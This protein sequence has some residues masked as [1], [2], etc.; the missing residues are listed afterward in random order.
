MRDGTQDCG[1]ISVDFL[2]GIA[3]FLITFTFI[4]QV[5]PVMFTPLQGEETDL[6]P[7]AYRVGVMLA[8]DPGYWSNN[9]N[10]GTDWENHPSNVKRVGLANDTYEQNKLDAPKI[11]A[12]LNMTN[13]ELRD[14]LGL[15]TSYK[16][17]NYNITLK[18]PSGQVI[19]LDNQWVQ[20][21]E[22]IPEGVKTE[23][24]TRTVSMGMA[25]PN[26]PYIATKSRK[27]PNP[28]NNWAWWPRADENGPGKTDPPLELTT[29]VYD[30][31]VYLKPTTSPN[32]K[33]Y[34]QFFITDENITENQNMINETNLSWGDPNQWAG[35][36]VVPGPEDT[37]MSNWTGW[38]Y[39]DPWYVYDFG[40]FIEQEYPEEGTPIKISIKYKACYGFVESSSFYNYTSSSSYESTT[41]IPCRLEVVVW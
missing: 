33:R 30:F 24:I 10:N 28:P 38:E 1:Q 13:D 2:T 9:T 29:P 8:E 19:K 16:T 34:F 27:L 31:V 15:N 12:M 11:N 3:I 20:M 26:I 4:L 37:N 21:G 36:P 22:P 7:V 41:L 40:D 25:E 39:N 6:H 32:T 14:K 17:Y 23:K 5:V 18:T 35:K